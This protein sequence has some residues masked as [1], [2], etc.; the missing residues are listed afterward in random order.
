M[1]T[2]RLALQSVYIA[3]LQK[4]PLEVGKI[5][6]LAVPIYQKSALR[7]DQQRLGKSI[8]GKYLPASL[9]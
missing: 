4:F 2:R 1:T 5:W 8:D 3:L 7:W 6:V 9:R